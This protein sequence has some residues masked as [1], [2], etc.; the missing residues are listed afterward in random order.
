LLAGEEDGELL[1]AGLLEEGPV[2]EMPESGFCPI[3]F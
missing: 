2:D 3:T 1:A